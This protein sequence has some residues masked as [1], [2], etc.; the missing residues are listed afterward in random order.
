[1]LCLDV[2]Q[3]STCF[4][5]AFVMQTNAKKWEAMKKRL[6]SE[7]SASVAEEEVK[8]KCAACAEE[9]KVHRS[10]AA[11]AKGGIADATTQH[12][13][14]DLSGGVSMSAAERAYFEPR[15]GHD[16]SHIRIHADAAADRA[17]S[18]IGAR[19]FTLG[20]RIAFAGGEYRPGT[21]QGC[22]LLAHELAHVVQQDGKLSTIDRKC[23]QCE[24]EEETVRR[25]PLLPFFGED[26]IHAPLIEDYRRRH[27]LPPGGVDEFGNRRG[28]SD[29]EIKYLLGPGNWL[30]P[31][32]DVED[33]AKVSDLDVPANKQAFLDTNC[34]SAS[35]QAMPPACAFTPRQEA[36]LAGAQKEAASRVRRAQDRIVMAG[37]QG[38]DYAKNLAR[39]VFTG[40]PP[41]LTE[42]IGWL[43][44]VSGFLSG[45]RIDFAG[46]TCG[47]PAC[48][49]FATTAYVKGPG[50]L[51]VY[52]CPLSFSYPNELSR[53]VLHEALHW[54]GLDADPTTP[55]GYCSKFDCLTPCQDKNTADAWA[56]YIDCLGQPLETRGSFPKSSRSL[57]RR[58]P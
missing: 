21:R 5:C 3:R 58:F 22:A 46:R 31:C 32:P 7:H 52:I 25:K 57:P 41:T 8:R 49:Q 11:G 20:E 43:A 19:A 26:P 10:A 16:F 28:P 15:F 53:T 54:A 36:R 42:A 2:S 17:A 56:H 9:E 27:G 30:P 48:Q 4:E 23:A 18:A 40:E 1:M 35:S 24:A 14:D 50:E 45:D 12:A 29:A 37:K 6:K 51:P 33:F 55:E 34:I 47:D 39:R 44:G 13:I 38:E